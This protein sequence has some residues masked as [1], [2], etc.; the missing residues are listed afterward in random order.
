M[1]NKKFIIKNKETIIIILFTFLFYGN[2]INNHY[3]FSNW[4]TGQFELLQ[5][6]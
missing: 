1:N 6:V 4:P 2:S 5:C 3:S